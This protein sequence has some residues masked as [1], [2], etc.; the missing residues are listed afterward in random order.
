MLPVKILL[1]GILIATTYLGCSK[2]KSAQ[3]REFAQ[4]ATVATPSVSQD[5]FDEFYKEDSTTGPVTKKESIDNRKTFS[6]ASNRGSFTPQFSEDGRYVV[7]VSTVNSRKLADAVAAQISAKGYPA[8]VATVDNPT[9]SLSGTYYRVRIG[10]FNQISQAR[11]FGENV[12]R[13]E[14]FEYW[15]D[16]KSNDAVGI[17]GSGMGSGRSSLYQSSS[18]QSSAASAA[19][20]PSPAEKIVPAAQPVTAQPLKTVPAQPLAP[21]PAPAVKS[22]AIPQPAATTSAPQPAAQPVKPAQPAKPAAQ[23]EWGDED[24]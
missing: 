21:S 14:G 19:L 18:S 2:K 22:I 8:Y 5:I 16:H 20:A 15:V 17:D 4:P 7:Q 9:P 13:G 3:E 12:L 24:W 1:T 23:N 11:A 10:G 6:A